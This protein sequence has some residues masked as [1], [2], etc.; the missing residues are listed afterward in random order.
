MECSWSSDVD[1]ETDFE[2]V[3]ESLNMYVIQN[4]VLEKRSP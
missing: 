4:S 2:M 1:Q 3:N